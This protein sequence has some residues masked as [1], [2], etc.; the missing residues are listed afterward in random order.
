MYGRRREASGWPYAPCMNPINWGAAEWGAFGQVG[1]L[2][3]AII[4]GFLVWKQVDQAREAREDQTRPYVIVDFEFS[5]L[6]VF[7]AVKNV[8]ASPA[9]DVTVAFD[10]PLERPYPNDDP[11]EV[12]AVFSEGI[13]MLAPGR[14][15]LIDFGE[16]PNFFPND[17]NGVPLRYEAKVRYKALHGKRSYNDPPLI[18]DLKPFQHAII[19]REDLR[20]IALHLKEIRKLMSSW[21]AG[22]RLKINAITQ[23][24]VEERDS[25]LW[26]ED[27]DRAENPPSQILRK[28]RARFHQR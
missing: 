9:C 12:F 13:P 11:D 21:T 20:Q 18:L 10:P 22:R 4:A 1:A 26:A 8:G 16:G 23:R 14:S 3:V 25:A 6:H 7:L 5:E 28:L 15:I 19:R 24:E 17:G 2:A 27:T